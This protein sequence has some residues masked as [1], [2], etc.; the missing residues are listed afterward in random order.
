SGSFFP[1]LNSGRKPRANLCS[2]VLKEY[3]DIYCPYKPQRN[4]CEEQLKTNY[5]NTK[6]GENAIIYFHKG[7]IYQQREYDLGAIKIL[8]K[9]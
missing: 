2:S 1:R 9:H 6:N 5:V 3:L 7:V 4:S 8:I